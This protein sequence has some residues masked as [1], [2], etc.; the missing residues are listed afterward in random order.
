MAEVS[1][2]FVLKTVI[3]IICVAVIVFIAYMGYEKGVGLV[4]GAK[5][6]WRQI[7][8]QPAE[9]P[10]P[11]T[12]APK[13]EKLKP[14]RAGIPTDIL[15]LYAHITDNVQIY[16]VSAYWRINE[17]E[18][19]FNSKAMSEAGYD[20]WVAGV[21]VKTGETIWYYFEASD[22]AGNTA[23]SPDKGYYKWPP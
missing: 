9:E 19:P 11:D 22:M 18:P 21:K 2:K 16:K 4:E 6:F 1:V 15:Y 8:G 10:K 20:N 3:V 7:T 17:A 23:R 5:L 14:Y 12:E 13:I